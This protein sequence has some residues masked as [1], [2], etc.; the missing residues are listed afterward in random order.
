MK[1]LDCG[2]D[3]DNC[4]CGRPNK[5]P[6]LFDRPVEPEIP[7]QEEVMGRVRTL[8]HDVLEVYPYRDDPNGSDECIYCYQSSKQGHKDDCIFDQ[9]WRLSSLLAG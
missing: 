8:V 2:F 6:R 5:Q 3:A 7:I 1:C 4:H 9:A